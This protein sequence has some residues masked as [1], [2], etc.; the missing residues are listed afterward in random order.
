[1]NSTRRHSNQKAEST[2][3]KIKQN[4]LLINHASK[5]TDNKSNGNQ[6]TTLTFKGP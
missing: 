6:F 1:M 4:L 5:S 2:V 3:H